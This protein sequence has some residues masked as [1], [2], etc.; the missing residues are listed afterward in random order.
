MTKIYG[1]SDDLIEFEGDFSGEVG[2]YGTDDDEH[3]VLVIVSDG[4]ILEVKYGKGG[5]GIWA[6]TLLKRGTLFEGIEQCTSEDAD[7]YSDVATFREGVTWAYA[8]TAWSVVN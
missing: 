6:I 1:S 4:T 7:P 2:Q 8:G 3:G 5:M